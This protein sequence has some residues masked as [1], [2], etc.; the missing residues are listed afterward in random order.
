MFIHLILPVDCSNQAGS[1]AKRIA[2]ASLEQL[3]A[4][5]TIDI[6]NLL[7]GGNSAISPAWGMAAAGFGVAIT[8]YQ[9]YAFHRD[10]LQPLGEATEVTCAIA[11]GVSRKYNSSRHDT[12]CEDG[13][14]A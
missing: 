8:L 14:T 10:V 3:A 5:T 1:L 2:A 11:G 7:S 6:E 9:W 13:R 4:L 12:Q